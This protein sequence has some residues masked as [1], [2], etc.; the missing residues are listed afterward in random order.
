MPARQTER[1][2]TRFLQAI[3]RGM[4]TI[5][6]AGHAGV[7]RTTPYTWETNDPEFAA[8]WRTIRDNRLRQLTDTAL[9]IALEGDV[10]MIKFLITRLDRSTREEHPAIIGEVVITTQEAAD[11]HTAAPFLTIDP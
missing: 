3:D 4:S 9:D 7:D 8:L 2:K 11:G 1:R 10:P 5:A 6:A